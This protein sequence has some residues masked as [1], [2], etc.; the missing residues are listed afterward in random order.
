M[1]FSTINQRRLSSNTDVRASKLEHRQSE[2]EHR[3]NTT[4]EHN[5]LLST[6]VSQHNFTNTDK[7]R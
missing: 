4:T 7:R 5:D 1:A 3:G 2:V 6:A